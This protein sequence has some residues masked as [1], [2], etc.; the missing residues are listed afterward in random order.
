D[1]S[2]RQ[3]HLGADHRAGR[4]QT[5]QHAAEVLFGFAVAILHRRI[6]I[7]HAGLDR[8]ADGPLLIAWLAAHHQ[9]ADRPAAEAQRRQAHAASSVSPHLHRDPPSDRRTLTLFRRPVNAPTPPLRLA[10]HRPQ[11]WA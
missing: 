4:L 2:G 3:S 9:A 5:L 10:L 6:E 8:A 11:D 1:I 7:I